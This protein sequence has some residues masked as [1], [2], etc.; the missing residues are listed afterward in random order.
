MA[1]WDLRGKVKN[2]VNRRRFPFKF[3]YSDDY[4]LLDLKEHVFPVKKY[5]LIYEKLLR[6]GAGREHFIQ[7]RPASDENLALAH[8]QKYIK[9]LRSV[10]LSQAELRTLE[11]PFSKEGLSFALLTVGGTIQASQNALEEKSICVHIGGG[12]HHAYADHGEGFCILNDVAVALI[13]MKTEKKIEKAMVVDC[14]VHQGNGTA[15]ILSDKDYAFTFS[16]HQMDIYPADKPA[17]TVDVGLWSGD[18]DMEYLKR[19]RQYI[20]KIYDEFRP[21]LIYFLAGADPYIK[22]QLGGLNITEA[23][24]NQRD[25]LIIEHARSRSIP[26]VIVLAGGYAFDIEDVA[27]IHI[28]TIKTARRAER[29]LSL[30]PRI[31]N[32]L[33]NKKAGQKL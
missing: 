3:V 27:G 22:D 9:K 2:I 32:P 18:G 24:L 30:S 7:P 19:L 4:W 12:F 28:S 25:Q 31:P 26:M 10:K 6:M 29:K 23:G 13:K 5:R 15:A 11:L 21:D 33:S 16:I 14:D 20:P 1:D 17:S 8:T